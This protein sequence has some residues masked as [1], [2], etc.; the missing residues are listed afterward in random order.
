MGGTA[1]NDA[2]LAAILAP[3]VRDAMEYLGEAKIEPMIEIEI[4]ASTGRGAMYH[5][6]E[7]GSLSR[8]WNT[9]SL[10]AGGMTLCEMETYYDPGE[11]TVN[12]ERGQH[13]T[14]R[15][16][17]DGKGGQFESNQFEPTSN[18]AEIIDKGL[19]GFRL[20]PVNPTRSATHFWDGI[21]MHFQADADAWIRESLAAA[22]LQVM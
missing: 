17:N 22:G 7:D 8:A 21:I 20:G 1:S 10:I 14:P 3:A 18:L 16:I 2:E 11:E 13:V 9:R 19:G 15:W 6:G 5:A 12:S 4:N